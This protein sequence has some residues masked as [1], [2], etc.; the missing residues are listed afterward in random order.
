MLERDVTGRRLE[1]VAA[2]LR[3]AVANAVAVA[4]RTGGYLLPVVTAFSTKRRPSEAEIG[5]VLSHLQVVV[6]AVDQYE[7]ASGALFP[8]CPDGGPSRYL[9]SY[10]VN[11]AWAYG[12]LRIDSRWTPDGSL[13]FP[14]VKTQ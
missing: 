14:E 13:L 5:E 8:E 7:S 1:W 11:A 6:A 4:E 2:N 12:V 9:R 3:L 10:T